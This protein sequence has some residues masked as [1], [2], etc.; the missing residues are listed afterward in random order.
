MQVQADLEITGGWI[1]LPGGIREG[2]LYVRDGK[3]LAITSESIIAARET[4]DATGLTVV[5]GMIDGHVHFQD[6]GDAT[7]EDFIAGSS[8]AALGGITMVIEHTHSHPVRSADM[9]HEKAAYLGQRSLIDYGL[10]A[11]A[12][13]E[14]LPHLEALWRAGAYFFKIF[15]CATHGVPATLPGTAL[16]L[17]RQLALIDGLV[18]VHCEDDSMT[19][20]NEQSLRAAGRVDPALIGLWRSREAEHVA[21]ATIALLTRL[22]GNRTIIAH[23]SQPA[24]VESILYEKRQGARIWIET[25]P[26]YLYLRE[27]ELAE[28]GPLRK[29]TPPMRGEAEAT[30]LW[31]YLRDGTL[32]HIAT[33]H[34]PSTKAQK[35]EGLHNIWQGHFGL[36]GV[37][38]TLTMLL[39]GVHE[40][41]LSLERVVQLTAEAPARLYGLWPH[42][43]NLLPGADADIVLLDLE[44]E[45]TLRDELII[46][47]AAWTPYHGYCV[48]GMPVATFVRG[49]LVARDGI[50]QA[51]PGTGRYLPRP[52]S[53]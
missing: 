38:T 25:C 39:N 44:R 27:S 24:I 51:S 46:S 16:D 43:G 4:I 1:V 31:N 30:G 45:H 48:R 34:A 12:W 7:R 26:Q 52:G 19:S 40:G 37:Q 47:K 36:P 23:V 41:R 49:T 6:P 53:G 29:F 15:T 8:S 18:M 11:H 3:V 21:T 32:S 14:D 2:V 22:A 9:L 20:V 33:D 13:P 5:P 17:F 50:I 10:A 35:A 28:F 42:K